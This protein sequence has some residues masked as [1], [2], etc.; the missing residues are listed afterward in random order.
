MLKEIRDGEYLKA[1]LELKKEQLEPKNEELTNENGDLSVF[2]KDGEI[3]KTN[4]KNI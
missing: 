4:L 1:T 3:V 2:T